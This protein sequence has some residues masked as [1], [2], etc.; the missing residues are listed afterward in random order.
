[1]QV[2]CWAFLG[3]MAQ[4]PLLFAT[5]ALKKKVK[6]D[7]IGNIIFWIVFCIIGQPTVIIL[8]YHDWTIMNR[9]EWLPPA[10]RP[11]AQFVTGLPQPHALS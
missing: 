5:E 7:Q 3:V 9:P 10:M 11:I 4:V 6:S 1:M 2:R 8:Y